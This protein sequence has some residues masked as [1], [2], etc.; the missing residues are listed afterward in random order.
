[1]KK[2]ISLA[3]LASACIAV[4]CLGSTH[5][6]G[7]VA[8]KAPTGPGSN[9]AV[10]RALARPPFRLTDPE[11]PAFTEAQIVRQWKAGE[12]LIASLRRAVGRGDRYFRV[13]SGN[14]RIPGLTGVNFDGLHDLVID[15]REATFW[16][17]C[18]PADAVKARYGL[19]FA[20]CRDVTIRGVVI[21]ADPSA[22]TQGRV[23]GI[24][25]P[26]NSIDIEIDEGFPV[27]PDGYG[28]QLMLYRANGELIPQEALSHEKSRLVEGRRFRVFP[29]SDLLAKFRDPG[30]I[31]AYGNS[32]VLRE[33]DYCVLP[34]RT[35]YGAVN[36]EN[37]G[38]IVLED[39]SI[40]GSPGIG[41]LESGGPGGNVFRRVVITRRPRTRRLFACASG[42]FQSR[43]MAKGALITGCEIAHCGDDAANLHGF[44]GLVVHRYSPDRYAI[45]AKYCR[46]FAPGRRLG[47]QDFFSV[48]SLGE[49]AIVRADP[50]VDP[51]I[52]DKKDGVPARMGLP[53]GYDDPVAV[54]LDRGLPVDE[55]AM[56][57][58]GGFNSPG[59]V[60]KDCFFH[61]TVGRGLLLNGPAPGTIENNVWR[62]TRTGPVIQM[63]SWYRLEGPC[64]HDLTLTGNTIV[65]ATVPWPCGPDQDAAQAA[66]Y[67]GMIPRGRY[68]R[69]SMPIYNIA[70]DGNWIENG[71]VVLAYARRARIANNAIVEPCR[72]AA[73]LGGLP[74]LEYYGKPVMSAI[75]V[76][77]CAD[78]QISGNRVTDKDNLC[79]GGPVEAGFL[80]SNIWVD[81]TQLPD[82]PASLATDFSGIQGRNGWRYGYRTGNTPYVPAE[83][84]EFPL[85]DGAWRLKPDEQVP[86][87]SGIL[88]HPAI[89]DGRETAV[90]RRWTCDFTG[91]LVI[92]GDLRGTGSGDGTVA[93]ICL[94]GDERWRQD[95]SGPGLV[96]FSASI[97]G[98]RTG[99]ILDFVLD[100]RGDPDS[101]TTLWNATLTRVPDR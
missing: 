10:R 56:V 3:L 57:D 73:K 41:I 20:N 8:K 17:A 6:A 97:L 49:A 77:V 28:G 91:T 71:P 48:D 14:Y 31:R 74:G 82:A 42:G 95:V 61:D 66:V 69:S 9:A 84:V 92:S 90:V 7:T 24:S 58:L 88:M 70:L 96:R 99:S 22:F 78:V 59:L 94:D 46:P 62:N 100:P 15:A 67:V 79:A 72:H 75:Y 19:T 68:L 65:P 21:D 4:A 29:G 35:G 64:P 98:I 1:M 63:E 36:L 52:R 76:T 40:Y 55:G 26:G 23:V 50:V 54:T 2:N 101:D 12:E 86:F 83:F 5:A 44:Y 16:I 51:A 47:F 81:G 87:I 32:F 18:D 80:T 13:K 25:Y 33:G 39:V 11:G 30:L 34:F 37:C 93:R 60:V 85:F 53:G 45:A 43:G 38:G 89:K 27:P